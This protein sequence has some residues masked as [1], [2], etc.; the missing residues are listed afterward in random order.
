M[1]SET[2]YTC[3]STPLLSVRGEPR[4]SSVV[5]WYSDDKLCNRFERTKSRVFTSLYQM[6]GASVFPMQDIIALS[7]SARQAF[8]ASCSHYAMGIPFVYDWVTWRF[9]SLI[10][11][12]N[13]ENGCKNIRIPKFLGVDINVKRGSVWWPWLSKPAVRIFFCSN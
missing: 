13:V 6:Y 8:V 2:L 12:W 9:F 7:S 1:S 4:D 5:S 3:S 10:A 11:S